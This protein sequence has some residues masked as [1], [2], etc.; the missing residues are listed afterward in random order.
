MGQGS[1]ISCVNSR[2]NIDVLAP[3]INVS[4]IIFQGCNS[5]NVRSKSR[6]VPVEI[7]DVWFN[8]SCLNFHTNKTKSDVIII[9]EMIKF[10]QCSCKSMQ[11]FIRSVQEFQ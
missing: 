6:R 4:S 10:E 5:I 11:F 2:L 3:G 1:S 7:H 9:M 8:N